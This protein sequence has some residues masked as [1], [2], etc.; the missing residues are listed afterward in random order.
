[1][2]CMVEASTPL[3][4]HILARRTQGRQAR[5][6][7]PIQGS[8]M[9]TLVRNQLLASL[10]ASVLDLDEMIADTEKQMTEYTFATP[11]C[12]RNDRRS[13]LK[14]LYADRDALIARIEAA[15]EAD[16][17]LWDLVC[18]VNDAYDGEPLTQASLAAQLEN[19]GLV[20]SR[21]EA[22]S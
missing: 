2:G 12:V 5:G 22:K 8:V 6:E 18:A 1:M 15:E 9:S 21:K 13:E 17:L 10:R 4:A 14:N 19:H 16:D 7:S 11:R 3:K 20:I